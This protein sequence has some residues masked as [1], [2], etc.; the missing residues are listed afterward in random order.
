M[1][2]IRATLPPAPHIAGAAPCA[3]LRGAR[4]AD[5]GFSGPRLR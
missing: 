3:G 1:T 2:P 5:P 4:A